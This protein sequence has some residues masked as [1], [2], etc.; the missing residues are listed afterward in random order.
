MLSCPELGSL[1]VHGG[2]LHVGT[3]LQRLGGSVVKGQSQ[4][5]TQ[6]RGDFQFRDRF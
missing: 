1:R 3:L 4:Q 5:G 2:G 6:K